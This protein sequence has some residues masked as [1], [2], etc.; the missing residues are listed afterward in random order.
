MI[1][2]IRSVKQ[3]G[4]GSRISARAAACLLLLCL[5]NAGCAA[6]E[7]ILIGFTAELSGHNATLGVQSRNGA[8]LA[9]EEINARG[10]VAGRTLELVVR[11][12]QGSPEAVAALDQE[13]IDMG[14]FVLTGHNT[15]WES[16]AAKSVID[17]RSAVLFSPSASTPLFD[18]RV[19][20][21]FRMVPSNSEQAR[22]LAGYAYQDM[23]LRRM[24]LLNDTD[25]ASFARPF[26]EAY[27]ERFQELGG[28]NVSYLHFS[29]KAR[30]DFR[31]LV[32]TLRASRAEA[33]LVIASDADTALIAQ[34]VRLAGWEAQILATNW[35]YTS[36]L[37]KNGGRAVDGLVLPSHFDTDCSTPAYQR[38]RQEYLSSYGN[39][40]AFVSALSYETIQVIG[41]ALEATGGKRDGFAE[42]LTS[43]RDFD[44]LCG[45]ISLDAH[46]DARRG[47]HIL[48]ARDGRFEL[49]KTIPPE[50]AP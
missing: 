38:F 35:S 27:R 49:L 17:A 28:Q 13:L 9:V 4:T 29:S 20:Y 34:Q 14:A 33:L 8:L 32:N 21:F 30:P 23:G 47:L 5:L 44:G 16:V 40:P 18:H 25:N 19:D 41:Q 10:G 46:G 42:T 26:A 43:V 48:K 12:N 2:L 45:K 11:D 50:A 36:A 22:S 37:I 7:P 39:E 31:A 15:S 3:S 6:G 24:A 1:V